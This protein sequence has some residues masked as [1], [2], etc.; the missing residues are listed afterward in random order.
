MTKGL[1]KIHEARP[2]TQPNGKYS[3]LLQCSRRQSGIYAIVD[4]RTRQVLYV[5]ESHTGRLYDTITRHF[6]RW[7]VNP[8]TD[9]TGRRFGGTTY[10]REDVA[11]VFV[12]CEHVHAAA[13]QF[14]EIQRLAPRD[15]THT[16]ASIEDLPI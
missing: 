3:A 8:R 6:R 11:V 16:G 14:A 9:A 10:K 13:L 15:N 12:V 2:A 4:R 7:R 1:L 5:G